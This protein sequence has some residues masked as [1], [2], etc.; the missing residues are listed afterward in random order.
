[1]TKDTKNIIS[2]RELV[3]MASSRNLAGRVKKPLRFITSLGGFPFLKGRKT[4]TCSAT[5]ARKG[6]SKT[7]E[8]RR[9]QAALSP[10]RHRLS[11]LPD[12]VLTAFE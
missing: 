8:N 5:A 4:L 2:V 10:V 3:V 9:G 12:N 11:L 1:M 6:T 7:R